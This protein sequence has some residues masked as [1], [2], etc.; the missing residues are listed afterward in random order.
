[1]EEL[2]LLDDFTKDLFDI[3]EYSLFL[4]TTDDDK[5]VNQKMHESFINLLD[6]NDIGYNLIGEVEEGLYHFKIANYS[7]RELRGLFPLIVDDD[8]KKGI[9]EITIHGKSLIIPCGFSSKNTAEI[10]QDW[11]KYEIYWHQSTGFYKMFDPNYDG[12]NSGTSG[13]SGTSGTS[14]TSGSAGSSGTS[15]TGVTSGSAGTSGTSGT[16]ISSFF[17]IRQKIKISNYFKK[18]IIITAK[19]LNDG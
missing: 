9:D 4:A 12:F 11:L 10:I 8:D 2:I 17:G 1:M 3:K 13:S 16:I 18:S 15:A 6:K 5:L 19:Q 14:G 7:C